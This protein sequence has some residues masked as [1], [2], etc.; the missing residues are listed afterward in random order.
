[1]PGRRGTREGPR[2]M[3]SVVV[4]CPARRSSLLLTVARAADDGLER[5]IALVAAV[6]E[7]PRVAARHRHPRGPR[8]RERVRIVDRELVEQLVGAH[9][10]ETLDEVEP[11]AGTA[12][13]DLAV[14]VLRID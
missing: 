14:E 11:L 3:R 7:D 5:V 4:R 13:A 6:L 9:P 1:M 10:R 8:P 2:T 12:E